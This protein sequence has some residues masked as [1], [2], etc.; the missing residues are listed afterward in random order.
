MISLRTNKNTQ[1]WFPKN[2]ENQIK[3]QLVIKN[4]YVNSK[5]IPD[6]FKN[7]AE[8]RVNQ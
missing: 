2:D 3:K 8:I 7:N 1:I 5:K 6:L 4:Q